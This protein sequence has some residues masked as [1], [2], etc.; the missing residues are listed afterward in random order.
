[1]INH[2]TYS[3]INVNRCLCGIID[4]TTKFNI[5]MININP[6]TTRTIICVKTMCKSRPEKNYVI[7]KTTKIIKS[8]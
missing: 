1:M 2:D 7:K 8:N 5:N 4:N 3:C 6:V